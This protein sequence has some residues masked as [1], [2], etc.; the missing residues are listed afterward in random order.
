PNPR[1]Q[2]GRNKTL[3]SSRVQER[4][5]QRN[6]RLGI[7]VKFKSV[8]ARVTGSRHQA[9][10]RRDVAKGKVKGLESS[11]VE[12]RQRREYFFRPRPLQSQLRVFGAD[13]FDLDS[14][15]RLPLHPTKILVAVGSV[16]ADKIH[17]GLQAIKN[18]IVD[19]AALLVEQQV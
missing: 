17:V 4:V 14:F 12:S 8:F 7:A 11:K 18:D 10:N 9:A 13:V 3:Q 1:T 16:D 6:R 2:S 5:P 19:D 15:R